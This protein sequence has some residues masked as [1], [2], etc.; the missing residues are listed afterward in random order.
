MRIGLTL[1]FLLAAHTCAIDLVQPQSSDLV[2]R[3]KVDITFANQA[4]RTLRFDADESGK[5]S[6][7]LEG[8]ESN[9]DEPA[10]RSEAKWTAD[11]EKRVISPDPSSFVSV[12]LAAKREHWYSKEPLRMVT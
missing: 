8:P 10:K 1:I 11:A 2:G 4:Q 6:F 5:G 3:W 9:W 12:M 7:L